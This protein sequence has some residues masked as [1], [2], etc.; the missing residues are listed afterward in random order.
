M[1]FMTD[2]ITWLNEI[3]DKCYQFYFECYYAGWP[4]DTLAFGFYT[5]SWFFNQLAWAFYDFSV[6][7]DDVTDQLTDI[8]SWGNIRS[9][10][11][12]WLP[13]LEGLNS[14]FNYWWDNILEVVSDWWSSTRWTVLTWIDAAV[15]GLDDL[16]ASWSTFWTITFPEWTGRL[17]TL[18][19]EWDNFWIITF[20]TLIDVSWIT[21]WWS[22][23][24]L[25]IQGIIDGAFLLRD[26]YWAGWQ[27]WRDVVAEFF[28]DPLGWLESKFT[29][30]FLGAE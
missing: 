26:Q 9:L 1:P 30:W 13:N 25:D 17:D 10:I 27:D 15:E 20:P 2:I 14:W 4:L 16:K 24:L 6:W 12:S 11:R 18:R 8:L 28:A 23:R 22:G 7:V 3:S 21:D 19:A 29:D 5:L